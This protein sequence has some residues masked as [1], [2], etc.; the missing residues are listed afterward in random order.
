M[1]I[2]GLGVRY[3]V[4]TGTKVLMS[5]ADA[6][7]ENGLVMTRVH[8]VAGL[9]TSPGSRCWARTRMIQVK[10]GRFAWSSLAQVL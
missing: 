8:V 1:D 10:W 9:V 3:P 2:M 4:R 5:E 6:L 7:E